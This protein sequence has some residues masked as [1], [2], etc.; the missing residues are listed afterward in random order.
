MPQKPVRLAKIAIGGTDNSIV[1]LRLFTPFID[2]A[3]ADLQVAEDAGVVGSRK[4][5]PRKVWID[6]CSQMTIIKTYPQL[7][8]YD[9]KVY[10]YFK[11]QFVISIIF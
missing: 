11:E 10:E 7:I 4:I 5:R 3:M 8:D 9:P 6:I 1:R 2:G